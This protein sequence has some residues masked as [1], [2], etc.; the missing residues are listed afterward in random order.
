MSN[1]YYATLRSKRNANANVS[2]QN[3]QSQQV[4]LL[5]E[6]TVS[7]L[8]TTTNPSFIDAKFQGITEMEDTLISSNLSVGG[9]SEF[10]GNVLFRGTVSGLAFNGVVSEITYAQDRAAQEA[11]NQSLSSRIATNTGDLQSVEQR[12][13][14]LEEESHEARTRL[15]TLEGKIDGDG[16]DPGLSSRMSAAEQDIVYVKGKIDGDGSI[17]GLSSRMSAAE[18]ILNQLDETVQTKIDAIVDGAPEALNTLN[19]IV[20]QL[21]QDS[22]TTIVGSLLQQIN[23]KANENDVVKLNPPTGI[24]QTIHGD[25]SFTGSVTGLSANL[26]SV[27]S[28]DTTSVTDR[29]SA[30]VDLTSQQRITGNKQIANQMLFA[31]TSKILFGSSWTGYST[32]EEKLTSTNISQTQN[33]TTGLTVP[34]FSLIRL[35]DDGTITMESELGARLDTRSTAGTPFISSSPVFKE[36]GR[37]ENPSRFYLGST[38]S[39][40]STLQT[41]M[42][43][44]ELT[45]SALSSLNAVAVKKES[46]GN[47]VLDASNV[48]LRYLNDSLSSTT[49][50]LADYC[51]NTRTNQEIAGTKTFSSGIHLST[52]TKLVIENIASNSYFVTAS[53]DPQ[54]LTSS[55]TVGVGGKWRISPSS[56]KL[57]LSGV[58]NDETHDVAASDY[59][60]TTSTQQNISGRKVFTGGNGLVVDPS[61]L[62]FQNTGAE[63]DL[64]AAEY[65]VNR[66]DDQVVQG[67]KTFSS[68]LIF[69]MDT[70]LVKSNQ[71]ATSSTSFASYVVNRA[72]EQTISGKKTFTS[73]L[74]IS[75]SNL[76]FVGST[77]AASLA[78]VLSTS[79]LL[80]VNGDQSVKGNK[81][82]ELGGKLTIAP[83]DF[84]LTLAGQPG[85]VLSENY[86][87]TLAG[88]QAI[89]GNKQFEG[90]VQVDPGKC[91]LK[92]SS[93]ETLLSDALSRS[94]LLYLGGTETQVVTGPKSF[95]GTVI[96]DASKLK[97]KMNVS[98][99]DSTAKTL[100]EQFVNTTTAQDIYGNKSFKSNVD[101]ASNQLTLRMT[102]T[103]GAD[104]VTL[105]Y[106]ESVDS[107]LVDTK[108]DQTIAGQKSFSNLR[109][110]GS[111]LLISS[112]ANVWTDGS[113]LIDNVQT[114]TGDVSAL[115]DRVSAVETSAVLISST[116][117]QTVSTPLLFTGEVQI[118]ASKLTFTSFSAAPTTRTAATIAFLNGPSTQ[119]FSNGFTINSGN[120][121]LSDVSN[122]SLSA[123]LSTKV[124]LSSSSDQTLDHAVVGGGPSSSKIILGTNKRLQVP[125]SN[126][127]ITN[128][129]FG[130]SDAVL[131]DYVDAR[132]NDRIAANPSSFIKPT[133]TRIDFSVTSGTQKVVLSS[134]SQLYVNDTTK[135]L[136]GN[137]LSGTPDTLATLLSQKQAAGS[138]LVSSD[139]TD[140]LKTTDANGYYYQTGATSMT[141]PSSMPLTVSSAS[142]FQ[143]SVSCQQVFRPNRIIETRSLPEGASDSGS[144]VTVNYSKGCV[145]LLSTATDSTNFKLNIQNFPL[146]TD[147]SPEQVITIILLIPCNG[148]FRRIA[149]GFAWSNGTTGFVDATTIYANGFSNIDLT[150]ATYVMQT[151][152]LSSKGDNTTIVCQSAV[153]PYW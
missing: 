108:F 32:L 109:V 3:K 73:P 133:D 39:P 96:A 125:E 105:T 11:T 151:A 143:N 35:T 153:T 4:G 72:E 127:T 40:T 45:E 43:K 62:L 82:F 37:I 141:I 18:Q 34:S 148:S 139:L 103:T 26:I 69:P 38:E 58:T 10:N 122:A 99:T 130:A 6:I 14:I 88:T 42:T 144:T 19:E 110:P 86:F 138:Y 48:V 100:A 145:F 13:T 75:P 117:A 12:T 137:D 134:N 104:P 124:T 28:S 20:T 112:S 17:P 131:K 116:T 31:D 68:G 55:K 98:E 27:S 89:T 8:P 44:T 15:V 7:N 97:V 91:T 41:W 56:L 22:N 135:I 50:T 115:R 29:L 136:F 66:R 147:T 152:T 46:N 114:V 60:M 21:N 23:T 128:R 111:G 123:V 74:V 79:S 90:N 95:T 140:Y 52:P 113:T 61:S 119:T 150:N 93:T 120:V 81:T 106:E 85:P 102:K 33:F 1:A 53:G 118:P 65:L 25:V 92:T 70:T 80:Y 84:Q 30:M 146:N 64:T 54:T 77:P 16:S 2:Y 132:A 5:K 149:S 83:S 87:M 94:T 63:T 9:N 76:Q 126:L 51:V 57:M 67:I 129:E 107:L 49:D 101:V 36:S 59:W 142:V 24:P 121:T 78:D 47:V 71:N